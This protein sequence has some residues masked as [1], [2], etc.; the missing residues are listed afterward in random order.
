M[1]ISLNTDYNSERIE[2]QTIIKQTLQ[3]QV[4]LSLQQAVHWTCN[5]TYRFYLNNSA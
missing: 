1:F 5:I 4:V 2:R 3:Q